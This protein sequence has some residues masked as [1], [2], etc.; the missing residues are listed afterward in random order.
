MMITATSPRGLGTRP[1]Q[2]GGAACIA[3]ALPASTS[4]HVHPGGFILEGVWAGKDLRVHILHSLWLAA[5][6]PR[7]AAGPGHHRP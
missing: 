4:V 2:G 7:R 6:S 1:C 5:L 3:A